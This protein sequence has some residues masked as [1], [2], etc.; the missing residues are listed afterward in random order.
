MQPNIG[1]TYTIWGHKQVAALT[2]PK[3]IMFNYT[4]CKEHGAQQI[5]CVYGDSRSRQHHSSD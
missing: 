3:W 5:P 2:L 4:T 1:P